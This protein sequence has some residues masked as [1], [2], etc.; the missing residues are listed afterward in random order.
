MLTLLL[1]GED[2]QCFTKATVRLES[3]DLDGNNPTVQRG[4]HSSFEVPF[5]HVSQGTIEN[6]VHFCMIRTVR[7]QVC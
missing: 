6:I 3:G 7:C 5:V 2:H 1:V 4:F